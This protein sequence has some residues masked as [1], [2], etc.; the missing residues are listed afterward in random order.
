[1]VIPDLDMIVVFT[2]NSNCSSMDGS[3]TLDI[4]TEYIIP[5]VE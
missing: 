4:I 2:A 5:A 1:M 3:D